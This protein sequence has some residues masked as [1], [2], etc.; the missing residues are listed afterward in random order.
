MPATISN[1]I[2][3]RIVVTDFLCQGLICDILSYAAVCHRRQRVDLTDFWSQID[4]S[5]LCGASFWLK[6]RPFVVENMCDR[7]CFAQLS[8]LRTARS[9]AKNW[10][11]CTP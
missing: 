6:T 8:K 7:L 11:V 4:R 9:P 10:A 1:K 5:G 3:S 2:N